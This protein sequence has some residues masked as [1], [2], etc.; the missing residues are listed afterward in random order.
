MQEEQQLDINDVL[1]VINNNSLL[2][3]CN[4]HLNNNKLATYFHNPQGIHGISHARRV[5]LISLV[6]CYYEKLN[7]ED[8]DILVKSSLYHDI[9][10]SHD[11]VC[12][13]HGRK[14]FEKMIKLGIIKNDKTEYTEI[15]RYVIENHCITDRVAFNNVDNYSI[16]D[17]KRALV[18]LKYFKDSDNLD[19]V[20]IGDLDVNYLRNPI[21]RQLVSLAYYILRN[22]I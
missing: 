8:T 5:L 12:F 9:G 18:L 20:R 3:I 10:R 4:S 14:S 16:L 1:E 22:E 13:E 15:L 17:R 6:I 7:A 11:G 19:R 21:S 2:D